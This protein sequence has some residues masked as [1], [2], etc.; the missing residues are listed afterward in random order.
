MGEKSEGVQELVKRMKCY[1]IVTGVIV[2]G[3]KLVDRI[4][5]V[6]DEDD[7]FQ[8]KWKV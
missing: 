4:M 7:D 5:F 8:N 6:A 3:H 2:V 1:N